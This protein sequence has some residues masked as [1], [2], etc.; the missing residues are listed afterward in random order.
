MIDQNMS[1]QA[2]EVPEADLAEQSVPAYPDDYAYGDDITSDDE[3]GVP[4][5][6]SV[7]G[8]DRDADPADVADQSI[9]VPWDDE[10]GGFEEEYPER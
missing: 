1:R 5:P 7:S 3:A 9:A 4:G 10:Y 2:D 8:S 6:A